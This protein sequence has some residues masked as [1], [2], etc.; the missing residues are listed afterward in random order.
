MTRILNKLRIDLKLGGGFVL[1][2]F[3]LTI[4]VILC[5]FQMRRLNSGM[6]DLYFRHTLPIQELGE[7]NALMGQIKSDLQLYIQ[8]PRPQFEGGE[9]HCGACHIAELSGNHHLLQGQAAGDVNRCVA[10]HAQ[11]ASSKDHGRSAVSMT[12]MQECASCHPSDVIAGQR[13]QVKQSITA[14][15]GRI[16]LIVSGY[17]EN[18]LLTDAEKIELESFDSDWSEYQRI[19]T[20]LLAQADSGDKENALHRLVGGDAQAVQSGLQESI[21]RL[22]TINQELALQAQKDGANT[23]KASLWLTLI[24]GV[25]GIIFA[26]WL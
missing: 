20:D 17:R 9:F 1:I 14:E 26:A 15:V 23:F 19:I 6:T 13:E 2:V 11:Q 16:N 7:A 21:S 25:T 12:N 18:L 5:V 4:S 24:F 10:C 3:I 22:V 8:I